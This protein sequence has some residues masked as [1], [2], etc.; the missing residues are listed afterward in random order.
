M[1]TVTTINTTNLN[2]ELSRAERA[3]FERQM[4]RT[5]RKVF[6]LAYRLSRSRSDAEDLTQEA[7]LRALKAY[8]SYEGDRPFENWIFRIVTRLYLDLRR[9]RDRRVKT[10]SYDAP[11]TPDGSDDSV[12][13]EAASDEMTPVQALLSQELSEEMVVSLKQLSPEQRELIWM[14]DVEGLPYKE[15]ADRIHAPVG[16]VRSRLHRA[17]K[18]LRALLAGLRVSTPSLGGLPTAKAAR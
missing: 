9:N 14:A 17:H 11:L 10:V 2:H 8:R 7:F 1:E 5:Y 16:T 4:N 12:H 18:Q 15:I 6:D 3:E 13:F